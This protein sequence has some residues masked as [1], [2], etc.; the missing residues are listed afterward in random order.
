MNFKQKFDAVNRCRSQKTG[1]RIASELA[2][3]NSISESRG[4]I[5]RDRIEQALDLLLSRIEKDGVITCSAV[6]EAEDSL[7][8]LAPVA[9]SLTMLFQAHAHIDMNW[10]WGYNETAAITT[11]TFRTVLD[12]MREYPDMTFMQSQASTYEIVEKFCPEMLPEIK[13]RIKEGRWE[14][15]AAEW[16]EP[17]KNMPDGESLTRQILQ[18]KK[19]LSKLLEIDPESLDLDF[20]P[21]TF[22]HNL[23]VPEIL[24]DAGIKYLYHC[25][26]HSGPNIY[27]YVS[28][29]GKSVHGQTKGGGQETEMRFPVSG[30]EKAR[31]ADQRAMPGQF[32]S[33]SAAGPY[34]RSPTIGRPRE[35]NCT[36]IWWVRPV[37]SVTRTRERS[38]DR[39]G[40]E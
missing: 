38:P 15:T 17:D 22:G 12:I 16:V 31:R 18:A 25:R 29:S 28:P 2:Y 13:E 26:A 6:S 23:N 24:T 4:G 37:S 10:K 20:V 7:S 36:R 33:A 3:L 21:D 9:K 27:K 34:F 5:Y 39:A 11:D 1:E 14:V 30:W 19:Y 35:A 32:S 8:D 40:E